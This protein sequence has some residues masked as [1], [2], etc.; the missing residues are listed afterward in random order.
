MTWLS[1]L[2]RSV[3]ASTLYM[4]HGHC[5]LWQPGLVW[6]HSSTDALIGAAYVS[7]SLTLWGLVR[8]IRLPF[9]PIILAFGVFILACGLTH[10]MEVW[11]LWRPTYWL[12]GSVKAVTALASLATGVLL[13]PV[14]PRVVRLAEDAALSESRRLELEQKN[15]EL[16]E[17]YGKLEAV[18]AERL[19]ESEERFRATFEQA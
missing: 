14:K 4:P 7:I 16:R 17:L 10:F 9:S 6:L 5:Y 13:Y 18:S 19:R 11:T 8:R 12:S 3:F 2:L 1:D 15:A